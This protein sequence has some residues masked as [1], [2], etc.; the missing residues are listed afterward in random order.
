MRDPFYTT[1]LNA[2]QDSPVIAAVK[3]DEDLRHAMT[4]DCAVIFFLYGTIIDIKD[5]VKIAKDGGKFA[6][7]H[8]DLVEGL[9]NRDISVEFLASNTAADGIISTRPSMIRKA[10]ELKLIA[11]QRFFLLD[12][13]AYDNAVHQSCNADMIDVLPGALPRVLERLTQ[14]IRQPIIASGLLS[15][16]QDVF[17]ALGAGAIAVSTTSEALWFM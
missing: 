3:S 16:K 8:V 6:L 15:D 10:K 12:S 5:K 4:S 7:V 11:I 14:S 9:S 17:A 1:F 2:V 13:I